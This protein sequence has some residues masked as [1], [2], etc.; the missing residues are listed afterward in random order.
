[1]I[2]EARPEDEGRAENAADENA[3]RA[4]AQGR[5]ALEREEERAEE[6]DHAVQEP[7]EEAR[8][9]EPEP[10]QEHRRKEEA[11]DE[12]PDVV[13]RQDA[14][15][16]LLQIERELEERGARGL[17]SRCSPTVHARVMRI[18]PDIAVCAANAAALW[19]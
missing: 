1:M 18:D 4:E 9:M 10:R 15:D 5:G 17:A 3:L 11:R 14:R 2:D 8:L 19:V 7:E 12:R 6:R 16:E 13:E